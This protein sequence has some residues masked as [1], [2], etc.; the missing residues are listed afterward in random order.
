MQSQQLIHKGGEKNQVIET[1]EITL[2]NG[3]TTV[4]TTV[5]YDVQEN[6]YTEEELTQLRNELLDMHEIFADLGIMVEQQ[7]ET[8]NNVTENVETT[9]VHTDAAVVELQE[10][11]RWAIKAR[12][13]RYAI[14]GISAA[15]VAIGGPWVIGAKAAL[16]LAGGVVTLG[17]GTEVAG[18]L[19]KK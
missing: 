16:I 12:H 5:P 13:K 10:A 17:A 3:E 15:A 2:P 9:E 8:L 11:K 7:G 4:L 1:L 14:W 6:E 18:E 19:V